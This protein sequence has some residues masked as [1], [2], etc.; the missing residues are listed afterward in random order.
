MTNYRFIDLFFSAGAGGEVFSL[1]CKQLLL[2]QLPQVLIL[3]LKRFTVGPY[4]VTKNKA[5]VSFPP[6][7]NMAPYSSNACLK[8]YEL[9]HRVYKSFEVFFVA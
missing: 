2:H 1:V 9:V 8:V 6:M 3:H 4:T 7:L 5:H